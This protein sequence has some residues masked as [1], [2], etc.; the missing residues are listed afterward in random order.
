MSMEEFEQMYTDYFDKIYNFFYYSL[1]NRTVAED[2]T[3]ITFLKLYANLHHY[4][5]SRA[6][7]STYLFRIARN[8]LNDHY[9]TDRREISIEELE[10]DIPCG[11]N[12]DDRILLSQ[13]LSALSRRE[14]QI[15]YYKYYMN[16]TAR[17]I[18]EIMKLTVTNVN[19]ICSRALARARR[20]YEEDEKIS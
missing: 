10:L 12:M 9:R 20:F 6:L 8:V 18:A 3:S 19:S 5:S 7:P 11:E 1:M 2:L 13:L 17:E 14:R 4:D 15:L 16:M